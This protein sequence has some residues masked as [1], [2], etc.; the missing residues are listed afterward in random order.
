[1][2]GEIVLGRRIEEREM[3]IDHYINFHSVK[4][5][6][7]GVQGCRDTRIIT[8]RDRKVLTNNMAQIA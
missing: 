5:W 7:V 1:M 8:R 6:R 4:V 3:K 2:G